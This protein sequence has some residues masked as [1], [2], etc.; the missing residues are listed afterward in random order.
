MA[1]RQKKGQAFV[2]IN[3]CVIRANA[4]NGTDLP[5]IRIARSRSDAKPLYAREIAING[6]CRLVYTPDGRILRCGARMVLTAEYEHV[7]IVR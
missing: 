6:P 2:S 1:R 7:E 4:R 5:P 3:A